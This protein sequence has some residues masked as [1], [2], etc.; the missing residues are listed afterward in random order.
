[1]AEKAAANISLTIEVQYT[2][3]FRLSNSYLVH[4]QIQGKAKYT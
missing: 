1:M 2:I 3:S 4:L